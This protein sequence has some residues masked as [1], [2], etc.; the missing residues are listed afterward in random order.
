M[1]V[2]AYHP[3]DAE[4]LAALYRDAVTV[5]GATAY[6]EAQC[7]VWAASADDLDRFHQALNQGVTLVVI[8]GAEVAAFA[9]LHPGN[10]LSLLYTAPAYARQGYATALYQQLRAIATARGA[11]QITTMASRIAKE[12]FLKLGFRVVSP[13]WVNRQGVL[14][15]RF[16]MEKQL[17]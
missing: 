3:P 14:M 4:Q 15:E 8:T 13:D 16:R 6:D 5:T 17:G 7:R 10:H 1:S 2:R 12:L 11:T 9:Q